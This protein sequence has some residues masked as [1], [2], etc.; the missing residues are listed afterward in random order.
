MNHD[1]RL[2]I[3][4]ALQMGLMSVPTAA[5]EGPPA[6]SREVD[7]APAIA[8][9]KSTNSGLLLEPPLDLAWYT[10]EKFVEQ[11]STVGVERI[12]KEWTSPV[13]PL[14]A[15]TRP[16]ASG[17]NEDEVKDYMRE[18]KRRFDAGGAVRIG[19]RAHQYARGRDSAANA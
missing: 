14:E 13:V 4:L 5:A 6:T 11:S 7:V 15:P 2:I 1:C 17:L 12:R 19:C 8:P 10:R 9:A 16:N 3:A 18:A